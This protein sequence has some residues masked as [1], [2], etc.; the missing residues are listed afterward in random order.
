MLCLV[1]LNYSLFSTNLNSGS[2]FRCSLKIWA[3]IDLLSVH[4]WG[5]GGSSLEDVKRIFVNLL[6]SYLC[7]P[8]GNV[9][10][11][12]DTSGALCN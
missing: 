2:V 8:R 9:G 4:G 3:V 12:S 10:R 5:M 7:N 1:R 11:Y 6:S